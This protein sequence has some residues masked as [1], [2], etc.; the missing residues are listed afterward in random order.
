MVLGTLNIHSRSIQ[1]AQH[2]ALN[3]QCKD[4]H[5]NIPVSKRVFDTVPAGQLFKNVD[6]LTIELD[7]SMLTFWEGMLD[8]CNKTLYSVIELLFLCFLFY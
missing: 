2:H 7:S 6:R 5:I 3:S 4:L 1:D 8:L